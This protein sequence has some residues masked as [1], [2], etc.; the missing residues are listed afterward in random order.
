MV[1]SESNGIISGRTRKRNSKKIKEVRDKYEEVIKAV[2]E[3]KKTGVK[4]LRNEE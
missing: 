1:R 3:M 4:M 2:K